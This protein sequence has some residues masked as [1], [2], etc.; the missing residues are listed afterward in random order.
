MDWR[1]ILRLLLRSLAIL[2]LLFCAAGLA[3]DLPAPAKV[4]ILVYGVDSVA[5]CAGPIKALQDELQTLRY[6]DGW[7]IGIVCNPLAWDM[8]LR[9]ADPP[10]TRTAF[11]NFIKHSTVL[12]A[13]IFR[14]SRFSYRHTLA[15]ELAH[16]TCQCAD[17]R[18]A[19]QLAR[20]LQRTPPP[21]QPRQN[22]AVTT[23]PATV[24]HRGSTP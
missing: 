15:H 10:P 2:L 21:L 4:R 18:K 24:S 17:E 20:K 12:N 9:I 22:A 16:V 8:L 14:E 13:A 11:S 19:E 23:A 7:T 1:E 5:K 3:D 6:P